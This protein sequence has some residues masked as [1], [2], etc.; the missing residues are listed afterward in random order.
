MSCNKKLMNCYNKEYKLISI[1]YIDKD[2]DI[3][4]LTNKRKS[5]IINTKKISTKICRTNS[6]V[7]AI[8]L[9]IKEKI[10]GNI[11]R[12]DINDSFY[13]KYTNGVKIMYMLND[14]YSKESNKTLYKKLKIKTIG[15]YGKILDESIK[16]DI[17]GFSKC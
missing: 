3:L 16:Y 5:L 11:S 9:E 8:K 17:V 14:A 4:L 15:L 6:G 7:C 1:E 2:I 13:V 10:I 12:V